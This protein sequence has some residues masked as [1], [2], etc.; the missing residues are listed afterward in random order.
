M[1]FLFILSDSRPNTRHTTVTHKGSEEEAKDD[2]MRFYH[3]GDDTITAG[4]WW[5]LYIARERTMIEK[6]CLW[7]ASVVT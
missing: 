5:L 3:D 4:C 2:V 6:G 7:L 1:R